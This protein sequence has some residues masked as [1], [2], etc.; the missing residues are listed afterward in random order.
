MSRTPFIL[1]EGLVLRQDDA[2]LVVEYDGDIELS[3]TLGGP[4]ALLHSTGGDVILNA[5]LEVGR[6]KASGGLRAQGDVRADRIEAGSVQVGG[7]LRVGSV[8]TGG[9]LSC[10][11]DLDVDELRASSVQCGALRAGSLEAS[12][13]VEASG[14]TRLGRGRA[15]SLRAGGPL[16]AEELTLSGEL[17]T[18][19]AAQV[20]QLSADS[21][22]IGGDL[23]VGRAELAGSL[24]TGGDLVGS[25]VE[26]GGDAQIEG[27]LVV[28]EAVV[29]GQ[30]QA[31]SVS[32]QGLEASGG[33]SA[34][35]I[36]GRGSLSMGGD[37]RADRIEGGDLRIDQG[38]VSV[39]IVSAS[40]SIH[41]GSITIKS[42]IVMAP[43]VSMDAA[44]SGRI[45][46]LESGTEPGTSRVKGCL[47]LEDLE[48]LFGNS[49]QFLDERGLEDPG[50]GPRTASASPPP[51]AKA[52]SRKA[53]AAAAPPP[54]PEPRQEVE[55]EV[56][57]EDPGDS[58]LA[59][60]GPVASEVHAA[61]EAEDDRTLDEMLD[62]ESDPNT[63][64]AD[65]GSALDSL[66]ELSHV[67]EIDPL[68][69]GSASV[70]VS[71][72]PG[73]SI[74]VRAEGED[75][76][77][78]WAD[79]MLTEVVAPDAVKDMEMDIDIEVPTGSVEPILEPEPEPEP[80]LVP[81]PAEDP[82]H[83]Q[84]QETVG[85]IV[86]CYLHTEMPPAVSRLKDLVEAR[87]Y[88]RVRSDITEIWN[89]LLKF[90]QKRGMRIQPQ[91][92]TTFNTINSLVRK[93]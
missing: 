21:A 45:S 3:A 57:V 7:D 68:E 1:P 67:S 93:L 42:D 46:V 48:E 9:A 88:G 5:A 63:N 74:Q 34:T 37:I 89:Q 19:G 91:V 31:R 79:Q 40:R 90:H 10:G 17:A 28:D 41:L 72:S 62:H 61:I 38:D 54:P 65:H 11:G 53:K 15:S 82:I 51:P 85:K 39:R 30:L 84:I 64:G 12:G 33:V 49:R 8:E 69:E 60:I 2:G 13:E 43:A 59:S 22:S 80:E 23:K 73:P 4:I 52:S 24:S 50:Y 92:T 78:G 27:D 47:S 76:L 75:D 56:E 81:E 20:G 55:V 66:I 71:S 16:E 14:Q 83:G 77:F 29:A 32:V 87:D 6:I 35:T 70:R 44:A 18:V 25:S 58:M 86:T 36:V 26:V